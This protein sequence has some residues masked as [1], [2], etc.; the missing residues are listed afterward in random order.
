MTSNAFFDKKSSY[1]KKNGPLD[2]IFFDGLHPFKA[3][4][5]DVLNTLK[6]LNLK[7][8][9][10]LHDCYP[11]IKASATPAVSLKEAAKMNIPDWKGSFCG[12]V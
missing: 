4:F 2:L 9:L 8:T 7:G 6:Y 1:L 12:D 11:P 10:V 3:S 5:K